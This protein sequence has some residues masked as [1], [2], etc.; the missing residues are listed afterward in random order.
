MWFICLLIRVFYRILYVY[1]ENIKQ[2]IIASFIAVGLI[3]VSS[4]I[5]GGVA[6]ALPVKYFGFSYNSNGQESTLVTEDEDANTNTGNTNTGECVGVETSIIDCEGQ[7]DGSI[8]TSGL[9]QLLLMAINILTGGIVIASVGG[10]IYGAVLYSSAGGNSEN[11]K[12]AKTIFMNIIIGIIMY[13][14]MYSFLNY[15][16]PGG[17]FN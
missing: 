2:K 16:I 3:A 11:I 6:G 14:A 17:I 7:S 15:L 9:W 1:M 5:M 8:E 10:V 13:V 12:K 4:L